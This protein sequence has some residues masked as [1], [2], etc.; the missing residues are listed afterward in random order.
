MKKSLN[1][2]ISL[3]EKKLLRSMLRS[4]S[5]NSYNSPSTWQDIGGKSPN[6]DLNLQ[7]FLLVE[8]SANGLWVGLN[9]ALNIV[10]HNIPKDIA[11]ALPVYFATEYDDDDFPLLHNNLACMFPRSLNPEILEGLLGT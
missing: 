10:L 11:I 3:H 2:S 4:G 9:L 1:G 8:G 6:Y 7:D 5:S